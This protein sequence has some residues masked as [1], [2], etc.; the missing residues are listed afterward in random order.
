MKQPRK[1][2]KSVIVRGYNPLADIDAEDTGG[3]YIGDS[4]DPN[5]VEPV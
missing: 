3:G 4:T 1:N 5:R 2:K